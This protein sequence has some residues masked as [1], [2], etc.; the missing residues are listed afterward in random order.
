MPC[1]ARRDRL[2]AGLTPSL[3]LIASSRLETDRLSDPLPRNVRQG[4]S[5]L[6]FGHVPAA[7]DA[8]SQ[9]NIVI[10]S[11]VRHGFCRTE[12]HLHLHTPTGAVQVSNPLRVGDCF[13]LKDA[14]QPQT[15]LLPGTAPRI[16]P[17][18]LRSAG[19]MDALP[20]PAALPLP[21]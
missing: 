12:R 4:D 8:E 3:A 2:L 10:A 13:V 6:Q 17:P 20:P 14:A 9:R 11:A 7:R 19:V 21:L 15:T 5:M 1:H 18:L 16:K